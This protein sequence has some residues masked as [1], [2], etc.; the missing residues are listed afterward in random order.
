MEDDVLGIWGDPSITGKPVGSDIA[1]RKKTLP[2]VHGLNRRAELDA[3]LAKRT[4]SDADVRRATEVLE[5]VGSREHTE[6]LAQAHHDKAMAALEE[7]ELH[8]EAASALREMARGLLN[9]DR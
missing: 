9:R 5:E 6:Q 2:I 4:P 7:A 1:R 3:L 8:G